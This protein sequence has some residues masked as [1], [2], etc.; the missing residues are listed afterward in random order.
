MPRYSKEIVSHRFRFAP[1][2][3][4][5]GLVTWSCG[6][7]SSPPDPIIRP[8]TDLNILTLAVGS[9]PLL[10]DS[11]SFYA[12]YDENREGEINFVGGERY[13]RLK[14]DRHALSTRP[15][16]SSFGPGDSVLIT[17]K[18]KAPDSL[19]FDFQP[20]GLRFSAG[21]PAELSIEYGHAGTDLPGDFNDDGEI[22]LLDDE[23]ESQLCI[24][25]QATAADP[26]TCL[27]SITEIE[28]DEIKAD[29]PGFS[30]FALAY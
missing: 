8:E 6:D 13:L 21:S 18:V 26:F 11:I 12:L 10:E 29:I 19:V 2:L 3:L 4:A 17:I 27:G 22:D 5:L 23:I 16:G 9:P 15:D 24:W 20:A 1:A 30:R 14:I 7:S 25:R 28:V